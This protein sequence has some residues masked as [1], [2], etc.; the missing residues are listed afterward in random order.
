MRKFSV[1]DYIL[2]TAFLVAI[3]VSIYIENLSW[4][5]YIAVGLV[6]MWGLRLLSV[7]SQH[8]DERPIMTPCVKKIFTIELMLLTALIL[9]L[10]IGYGA[11]QYITRTEQINHAEAFCD[12]IYESHASCLSKPI[13]ECK[14][15]AIDTIKTCIV[16]DNSHDDSSKTFTIDSNKLTPTVMNCFRERMYQKIN[17]EY[18]K[19]DCE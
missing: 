9:I 5:R 6:I 16:N 12:S 19:H 8:N 1:T 11:L 13:Y 14:E 15:E 4:V 2:A 10:A 3:L 17:Q 18:T 7:R